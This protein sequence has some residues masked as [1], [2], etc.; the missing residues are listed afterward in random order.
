M[1]H[2]LFLLFRRLRRPITVIIIVYGISILGL[3]LIPGQDN[4]GNPWQMDF[5]HAFYFVSFMGSTIGFGEIPYPFT[6]EQRLWVIFTIYAT[7]I[8]WLYSIGTIFKLFQDANFNRLVK[9]TRFNYRVGRLHQSFY[10]VCGFGAT[11]SRIVRQL[12]SHGIKTVVLDASR[13]LID[14][15]ESEELSLSVP[16]LCDDA[17]HPDVLELAGINSNLCI[18]VLALTAND[19]T[20]LTIAIASKLANPNRVVISRTQC[21]ETTDNLASFGT[22]YIIDP[23]KIFASNL[24]LTIQEP[25][26]QILH[27]MIINPRHNVW[28]SPHQNMKGL[29]VICGYGRLGKALHKLFQEHEIEMTFIEIDPVG[30]EAPGGTIVGT[31]TQAKT[32]LKAGLKNAVG[33]I[34]GT[35]DDADNLSIII[36]ARQIKPDLITVARQND[37]FNKPVFRAAELNVL[38]ESGRIISNEIYILLRTPLLNEFFK[39]LAQESEDW[40]RAL[41]VSINKKIEYSEVDA[42]TLTISKYESL[43][44]YDAIDEGISIKIGHLISDPRNRKTP[45]PAVPLLLKRDNNFQ[46]LP[47][48]DTKLRHNDQILFCGEESAQTYMRWASNNHN[49]MRFIRNGRGEPDGWLWRWLTEKKRARQ[50]KLI[51]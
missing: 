26:K 2:V 4:F 31:G 13:Q 28:M 20:N 34:A 18:G 11:G 1:Y 43:A 36:T 17:S 32:L 39:L 6:P 12:N 48:D 7:V 14:Q 42:W 37:T 45:L 9:R 29:W 38:V 46:L 41:I 23:F 16:Y 19:H 40:T 27:N 49:V 47:N 33:I 22:D 21:Q 24:L 51:E 30:T 10:I 44:V 3:T 50:N 35:P 8:S 15:L 5:F 25:Y